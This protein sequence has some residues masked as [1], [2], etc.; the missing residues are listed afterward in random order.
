MAV[1]GSHATVMLPGGEF[2]TISTR[3]Q[4]LVVG[5]ECWIPRTNEHL[6]G[7]I[8]YGVAV[9][10]AIVLGIQGGLP[11]AKPV[12]AVVSLDINP[13]INLAVGGT[14]VLAATGM[15][16]SG[17]K[18]LSQTKVTGLSVSRAVE[19][20]T[21]MAAQDGYVN[22]QNRVIVIGG[23]VS[24]PT[25]G[26]FR[27]VVRDETHLVHKSHWP[28]RV[29]AIYAKNPQ[30]VRSMGHSKVTVGRY[31]LWSRNWHALSH[32][33]VSHLQSMPLHRLVQGPVIHPRRVHAPIRRK[34]AH[35]HPLNKRRVG[36]LPR[37]RRMKQGLTKHALSPWISGSLPTVSHIVELP[38]A[39]TS[40][41]PAPSSSRTDNTSSPSSVNRESSNTP[42]SP[43]TSS[44]SSAANSLAGG[45][46]LTVVP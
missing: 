10:V 11:S 39:S 36:A 3:G 27:N 46:T 18:I 29:V 6:R 28:V 12:T 43:L 31:L 34:V 44:L 24:T 8:G 7:I 25:V 1:S 32:R 37:V 23:A 13:S 19:R 22:A 2:R 16:A 30:L 26:W 42:P 38:S 33:P 9:T 5:Q 45:D 4:A 41:L 14:A 17:K 35:S 21:T 15:D 40:P 20:L